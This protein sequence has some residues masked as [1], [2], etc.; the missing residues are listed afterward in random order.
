MESKIVNELLEIEKISD[1]EEKERK[2]NEFYENNSKVKPSI[3]E[4]P[5]NK[6][7]QIF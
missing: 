3:F 4:M 2:L 5:I 6:K 7:R 1:K